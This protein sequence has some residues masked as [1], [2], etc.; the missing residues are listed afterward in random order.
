MPSG[1]RVG[2]AV[3]ANDG[4]RLVD[5]GSLAFVE[6]GDV[7][8][9]PADQPPDPGDFL[10][11]RGGVDAGPV[12]DSVDGGGQ[13]FAGAQQII[14]VCLQVGQVGNVGAE[15]VAAR[16]AVPDRAG[17]SAGFD[18]G[19]FGAGAVGDGDLADGVAGAFGF[20]QHPRVAPDPV[21]VPVEAERGDGVDG[22]AAAVFA[23]AVVAAGHGEAAVIE[24]FG[25]HVDRN[26]GVGVSLG[27]GVT[28]AIGHYPGLVELDAVAGA[29][30]RQR[31]EPVT[32]ACLQGG[33]ADR[34]APVGISILGGQQFQLR[35]RS[36]GESF[37]DPLLLGDDRR[38]RWPC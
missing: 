10:L 12:V 7:A 37:T 13:P 36:V 5:A 27:V 23:D 32:V 1:T 31:G 17:S 34:L 8:F 19:R 35:G 38:R 25:Q 33:S 21:A 4:D 15:V 20:Q 16:A 3:T 9:D 24:Q 22:G 26:P 29:Q 28:I 30:G 18:V 6:I 2:G 11:G 14:E